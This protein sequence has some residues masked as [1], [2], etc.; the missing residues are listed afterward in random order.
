MLTRPNGRPVTND[1]KLLTSYSQRSSLNSGYK[2]VT[3]LSI[4]VC[5]L[6]A[7]GPRFARALALCLSLSPEVLTVALREEECWKCDFNGLNGVFT[8]YQLNSMYARY[9]TVET[10]PVQLYSDIRD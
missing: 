8:V 5:V 2:E 3:W 1:P 10:N 9:D 6:C 7:P 4:L